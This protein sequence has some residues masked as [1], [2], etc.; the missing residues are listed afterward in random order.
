VKAL[1]I[2][3]SPE[4]DL[5]TAVRLAARSDFIVVTDG[6]V[7]KLHARISPHV[8]CGDFD[9]I[10]RSEAL[11]SYPQS[12]FLVLPDQNMNDL[13][14]ATLLL[15]DKGAT[16]IS[17]VCAVGGRFDTAAA[18]L[19][20]VV[21]YHER[22][23]ITLHQGEMVMRVVS[24]RTVGTSEYSFHAGKDS[25]V[26]TIAMERTATVSLSNVAWPLN[27]A[28]LEPGSM[29]VSNKGLGLI[30]SITVHDGIVL[31]FHTDGSN[32]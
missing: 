32:S 20:V 11:R 19:G 27:N 10:N 29:G 25:V 22:A 13:E 18:N 23:L 26:S 15:L 9:S 16:E 5:D 21:R 24:N 4:F 7:H 30:A 1:L 14:K 31:V 8:V 3:D 28:P 12:Q 2:A 6:A 17:V